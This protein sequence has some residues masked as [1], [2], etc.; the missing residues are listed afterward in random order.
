[1]GVNSTEKVGKEQFVISNWIILSTGIIILLWVTVREVNLKD[2]VIS[3]WIR[4][5]ETTIVHLCFSEL[6]HLSNNAEANSTDTTVWSSCRSSYQRHC[7][8]D[9]D[10]FHEF[11]LLCANHI[12]CF[13]HA[14]CL[15]RFFVYLL[16]WLSG[17]MCEGEYNPLLLPLSRYFSLGSCFKI[18]ASFIS[19]MDPQAWFML[20]TLQHGC[21]FLFFPYGQALLLNSD[22]YF[23]FQWQ[24]GQ[25]GVNSVWINPF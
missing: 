13:P 12:H 10:K 16:P 5:L 20:Y 18:P 25:G 8:K 24:Q 22:G 14:S 23:A 15:C 3:N 2:S 19:Q 17:W 11:S 1:M 4:G 21:T 6:L 7:L 9:V